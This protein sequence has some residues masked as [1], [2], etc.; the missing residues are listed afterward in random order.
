M[1]E[2]EE[3]FWTQ[4]ARA[5]WLKSG[6]RNT[7]FFHNYATKKK[8]KNTTKGLI[9]E[10]GIFQE[11]GAIMRNIIQGYFC[12]FVYYRGRG[13]GPYCS[14]RGPAESDARDE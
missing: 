13:A 10:Q 6:D 9:D 4:R 7:S 1:L 3:I 14:S 12:E 11:D 5:N 8:K 2:Q